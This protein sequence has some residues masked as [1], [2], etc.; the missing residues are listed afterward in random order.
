M[1][2]F[3]RTA[4]NLTLYL[5]Q[6]IDLFFKDRALSWKNVSLLLVRFLP[7]LSWNV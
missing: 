4:F 5:G 7:V 1:L 3:D 6:V 2:V